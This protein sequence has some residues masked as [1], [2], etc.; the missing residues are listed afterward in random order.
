MIVDIVRN[1]L[2]RVATKGSV[3][4]DELFGIYS[5]KQVHQ[6][7]STISAELRDGEHLVDAIKALFP[8]GSMTG[9]PK[10]RAMIQD[11]LFPPRLSHRSA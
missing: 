1:D 6:M 11:A 5:F 4:V 3:H 9:A 10:V 7:I 8:M 2:S